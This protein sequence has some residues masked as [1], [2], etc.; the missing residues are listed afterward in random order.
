METEFS[1]QANARN[2][3]QPDDVKG[4]CGERSGSS[5]QRQSHSGWRRASVLAVG[6]VSPALSVSAGSGKL[7]REGDALAA[8]QASH[9]GGGGQRCAPG[10]VTFGLLSEGG[11]GASHDARLSGGRSLKQREQDSVTAWNL[12]F[13][14]QFSLFHHLFLIITGNS[15]RLNF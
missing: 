13:L 9:D 3:P 5:L 8:P 11:G 7:P 2:F 15:A 10:C 1:L 14:S 6:P 12:F 4:R